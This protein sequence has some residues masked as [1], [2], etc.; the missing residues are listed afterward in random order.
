MMNWLNYHHLYYFKTIAEEGSVSKASEKL[1][2]GQPTLSA[3]LKQ[4]E[5]NI[6]VKLFERHHKKLVLTEQGRL[7]LDY[8]Q[9]IFKIGNE[10]V[11]AL[12]DRLLPN[13]IHLQIG[14]L[15][16]LPKDIILKLTRNAIQLGPCSI[17]LTEGKT[18][19][20]LRELASHRLDLFVT[21]FIPN[22]LD[23]KIFFYKSILKAPLHIYGAKK[24]KNLKNNFPQSLANQ[25]II[26]PTHD[27]KNR[28]DLEHWSKLNAVPFDVVAEAQDVSLKTLLA[29][30]GLGVIPTTQSSVDSLL[31][32]KLLFD[33]GHLPDVFEEIYLI[34]AQRKILNPIANS[35][36]HSEK[37]T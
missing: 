22:G 37:L 28:Q 4:F 15:D 21:N 35:L 31:K 18:E 26:L 7:A 27:S 33:L 3:Q 10:M 16:G 36:Y 5:D 13:R 1:R 14:A 11:E 9:N 24:F 32:Q 19:T 30:E 2:L 23:T 17:S 6:G 25:P 12:H 29:Q 8:A 20:L 34:T